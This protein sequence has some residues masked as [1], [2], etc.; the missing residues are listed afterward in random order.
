MGSPNKL[1]A[2]E[3]LKNFDNLP[4]SAFVTSKTAATVIGMSDAAVW[5]FAKAGRLTAKKIGLRATRFNVGEIRALVG[6]A[7]S[8]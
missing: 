6:A 8:K 5:R 7:P 3:A 4:D 1:R 2:A